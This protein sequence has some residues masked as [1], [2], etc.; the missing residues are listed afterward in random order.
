MQKR[1]RLLLLLAVAGAGLL[2]LSACGGGGGQV[3]V[4]P[5][6][7][8][9]SPT[10]GNVPVSGT[11]NFS[12]SVTNATNTAV[13]WQVNGTAGGNAMTT[14]SI[15]TSGVFTA[16]QSIPNPATVS[17][18]AVSQQDNKT[19]SNTASV[20]IIAAQGVLV[21]P[22]LVVVAG[23]GM[24]SFTATQ[25]GNP[26]A[27]TWSV[28]TSAGDPGSI[29]V[30]GNFTA[31]PGPPTGGVVTIT[32]TTATAQTGTAAATIQLANLLPTG[33]YAFAFSGSDFVSG[34][35]SPTLAIAAGSFQTN[36]NGTIESGGEYT[37]NGS[38]CSQAGDTIS[39]G[40]YAIGGDGRGTATIQTAKCGAF[41]WSFVMTSATNALIIEFN[42]STTGSFIT[43]SGTIDQQTITSVP[44]G[45]YVFN[46]AGDDGNGPVAIAG[47]FTG[48]GGGNIGPGIWDYNE[49]GLMLTGTAGD[50]TLTGLYTAVDGNGQGQITLTSSA[51][52]TSL[53]Y[54]F[55]VVDSTH[56]K[57][58]EFDTVAAT[59]GDVFT[60]AATPALASSNYAFTVAGQSVVY[61]EFSVG[62]VFTADS[63]SNTLTGGKQDFENTIANNTNQT[64]GSAP[65]AIT[66]DGSLARG[67]LTLNGPN[68]FRFVF[69]VAAN[70]SIQLVENANVDMNFVSSGAAYPQSAT[71]LTG[72]SY[73]INLTGLDLSTEGGEEDV[74]GQL[75]S[76]SGGAVSVGTLDIN[77]ASNIVD[78]LFPGIAL[79]SS[80][81]LGTQSA[82]GYGNNANLVPN[83]PHTDAFGLS[84]YVIDGQTALIQEN[85]RTR[86]A[87]GTLKLQ[88]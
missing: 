68:A 77:N 70:G 87:I 10:S 80:S 31:P 24:Q 43:G 66:T 67:T 2:S 51:L 8:A 6:T 75:S 11:A 22:S 23:G 3:I 29:D 61:P 7:V 47:S 64:L 81:T 19:T 30:N 83:L 53:T 50:T 48:A 65:Y 37:Y 59:A 82:I 45:N 54:Y 44:N 35:V 60:A 74:S 40:T 78:G 18:T 88:F 63:A 46:V 14:G 76:S 73:G 17:I 85:D 34:N 21:S 72:G 36:G 4:V 39:G 86:I 20:T 5:P 62:G 84:V 49:A 26:V 38:V 71:A 79:L 25:G 27:V 52:E 13:T 1:T 16:P 55:Y 41:N 57:I 69:Y 28:S 56:L 32:A 9:I 15:S 12:V 58:V 33:H 42:A